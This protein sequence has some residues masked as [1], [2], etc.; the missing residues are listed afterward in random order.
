[1]NKPLFAAVTLLVLTA[2]APKQDIDFF[3]KNEAERVSK[4][5]ECSAALASTGNVGAFE[6]DTACVAAFLAEPYQP[7]E[8][9][10]ENKALRV[11]R[12][13]TC[14]A[15]SIELKGSSTCQSVYKFLSSSMSRGVPVKATFDPSR[16]K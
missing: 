7:R 15:V 10:N 1:M 13:N 8:F 16:W 12:L 14:K 11:E 5:A 2:C 9:W 6:T 3:K 4:V